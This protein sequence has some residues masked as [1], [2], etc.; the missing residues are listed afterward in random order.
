MD[1]THVSQRINQ[2]GPT[3]FGSVFNRSVELF[4][5]VWLQ[6]FI[7]LLLTFVAIIPLYLLIYAP[8]I[9]MGITDPEAF[10]HNEM[11]PAFAGIMVIVM[12]I[13]S[14]GVMTVGICLNAAFLRICRKYDLDEMG[15]D[16][17]FFYF[18]KAYLG[19]ALLLSL[20]MM[21]LSLLGLLACGLGL[22]YLVVPMSLFPSFFAFDKELTAMEIVKSGFA[23]GNKNW[24]IIFALVIVV[25][26][27]AQLGIILCLVGIF[28]TAMF[29]K[30]PIYFI[31]KDAIGLSMDA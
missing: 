19:K 11:P 2:S 17:Y 30:I 29:S 7:T 20:L 12:P 9:A 23:L 18:K 15:R 6:G 24:L 28:F 22:I 3:E 1:F 4:K 31:Y 13:F 16:D 21:C 26:L 8:M 25:G 5:K 27:V 14:I 10:E